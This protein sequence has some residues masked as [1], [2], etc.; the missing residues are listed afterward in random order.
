MV[1]EETDGAVRFDL[2]RCDPTDV[3]V[4]FK[5]VN[6]LCFPLTFLR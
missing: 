2:R 3:T 1:E 6:K 5:H 4:L